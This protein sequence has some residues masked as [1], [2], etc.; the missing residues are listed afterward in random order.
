MV[1]GKAI[2]PHEALELH[3]LVTLKNLCATK[4]ASMAGLVKDEELK[5]I[6]QQDITSAQGHIKELENLMSTAN[7]TTSSGSS[8]GSMGS[9][10]MTSGTG[11]SR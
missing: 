9:T 7:L 8:M 4:S 6:L 1:T 3:E 11:M 5:S 10:T 2:A